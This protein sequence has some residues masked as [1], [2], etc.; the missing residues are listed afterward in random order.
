MS[1]DA[2]S[3]TARLTGRHSVC[4]K[5]VADPGSKAVDQ[6]TR[7][8]DPDHGPPG[9]G[10]KRWLLSW[11]STATLLAFGFV[12][13]SAYYRPI[14]DPD[15]FWHLRLGDQLRRT[16][17][18]V[19]PEPWSELATRPLV[20]HEWAPELLYAWA[21]SVGGY[22][23]LAW[24]QGAGATLVLVVLYVCCRRF[25]GP[26]IATLLSIAAFIGVA[27]SL[28][29]RPQVMSIVLLP[30]FVAA[31]LT[32]SHDR[33]P[34]WWLIPLTFLW[35]M[36]HGMWFLGVAVGVL[37]I[38]GMALDRSV[39]ARDVGRLS[40]VPLLSAVVVCLT[41][42]GP[43]LLTTAGGMTAYTPFVT[44]WAPPS[45][46]APRSV[47]TL[48]IA[49]LVVLIWSRRRER[50]RWVDLGIWTFGVGLA[51]TYTRTVA[52]G[53]AVLAVL[54]ASQ[55]GQ[56]RWGVAPSPRR[57]ALVVAFGMAAVLVLGPFASSVDTSHPPQVP[58]KLTSAL[59]ALPPGTRVFNAYEL[60]GWLLWTQPD[61]DPVI[62]G[63]ADVYDVDY[64][65]RIVDAY[66]LQP[67]WEE[68]VEATGARVAV[69]PH[70]SQLAQALR[71]SLDWTVVDTD[72][73]FDL[74]VGPGQHWPGEISR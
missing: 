33:K 59:D 13:F 69:L 18:F 16:W 43:R 7:A 29:V 66:A 53:A 65:R 15:T 5:A 37:V 49:L 32:T 39:V 1:G 52:L 54:A 68:S 64:F 46:L 21:F 6:P 51:L 50:T 22:T 74:L 10:V 42:L 56:R 8:S 34:R 58:S 11:L 31:W 55:V 20:Y 62:D 40:L 47:A 45:L 70:T 24:I 30:V 25:T 35:A 71:T 41:P 12:A 73:G 4:M 9:G 28:L 2:K 48:G 67:G 61:L 57:E 27:G 63:R 19:G 38:A 72:A 36:S 17:T 26:P 3:G 14:T 60:G 44:E 23:A